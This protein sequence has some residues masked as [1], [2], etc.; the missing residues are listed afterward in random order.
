MRRVGI[1]ALARS[2]SGRLGRLWVA[3]GGSICVVL[4]ALRGWSLGTNFGI[5]SED[6]P[7]KDDPDIL[8]AGIVESLVPIAM[9]KG[10]DLMK[11]ECTVDTWKFEC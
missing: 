3:G 1:F 4:L 10:C 5:A 11:K 9:I 6:E 7:F 8:D 2:V